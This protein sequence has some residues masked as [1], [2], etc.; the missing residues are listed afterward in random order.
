VSQSEALDPR[1]KGHLHFQVAWVSGFLNQDS[2]VL[3]S[4][5]RLFQ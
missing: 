1:Q 2:G 4:A 3:D 5:L